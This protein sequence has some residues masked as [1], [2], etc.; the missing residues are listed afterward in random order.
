MEDEELR[1][2]PLAGIGAGPAPEAALESS[3]RDVELIKE[4][5]SG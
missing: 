5:V 1:D 4:G 2:R 3:R